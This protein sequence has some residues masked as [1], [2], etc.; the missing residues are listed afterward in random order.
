[1]KKQNM[2]LRV[3]CV[4]F[5]TVM[6]LGMLSACNDGATEPTIPEDPTE[7]PTEGGDP[8]IPE[9][10]TDPEDPTGTPGG[11]TED[12]DSPFMDGDDHIEIDW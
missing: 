9:D 8:T 2:F 6:L 10:P 3:L 12:P 7:L 11:E 1:M 5:A 4:L